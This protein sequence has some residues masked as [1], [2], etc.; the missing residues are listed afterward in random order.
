M[1]IFLRIRVKRAPRIEAVGRLLGAATPEP[2]CVTCPDCGTRYVKRLIKLDRIDRV[3]R[4]PWS[5]LQ[6]YVGGKLYR[7]GRCRLQF[8]DCRKLAPDN[9][10]RL[11]PYVAPTTLSNLR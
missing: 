10:I 1:R 8:Y 4:A 11:L 6:R 7:C 2:L 3:S 9:V 5:S